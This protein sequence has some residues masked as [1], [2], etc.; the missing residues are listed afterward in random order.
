MPNPTRLDQVKEQLERTPRPAPKLKF[1]Q[2]H[3][4]IFDYEPGDIVV[5]GYDPHPTI[6]APVAV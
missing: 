3:D 2:V 4:S 5:E 6:K 1:K